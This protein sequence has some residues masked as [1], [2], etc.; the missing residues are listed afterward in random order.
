RVVEGTMSLGTLAAFMDY[1]ARIVA[2]VQ[3]LM[4][5]YSALA[6]ARVSWRRFA[7]LLDTKPDVVAAPDA[8]PL[9]QVHGEIEFDRVTLVHPRGGLL[10]DDASFK[11]PAG[12]TFAVVGASGS[13]KSTIGD[14]IVRLLDPDSGTVRLDGVDLRT[15]AL[16]DLRRHVQSVDQAPGLFHSTLEWRVR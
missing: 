11:V 6:T 2:P 3:A 16:D 4:G 5:L 9:I 1:Q 10:L 14:L 12:S 15:V 13:G 7:E 8:R